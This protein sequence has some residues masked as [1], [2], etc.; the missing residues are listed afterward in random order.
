M[1]TSLL[2]QLWRER[3]G[4]SDDSLPDKLFLKGKPFTWAVEFP[5]ASF[6]GVPG[7]WLVIA[8]MGSSF[9]GLVVTLQFSV[10]AQITFSALMVIAT[11]LLRRYAGSLYT[12]MLVY[13]SLLCT[14][15]YFSWRFRHLPIDKIDW[16]FGWSLGFVAIE[17]CVF[18]YFFLGWLVRLWPIEIAQALRTTDVSELPAVDVL[19]L[20]S[21]DN[22]DRLVA[23]LK[24]CREIVWP[25]KKLNLMVIGTSDDTALV[26]T[27]YRFKAT[28]QRQV[29]HASGNTEGKIAAVHLGMSVTTSEVVLVI[30]A[31]DNNLF[32]IDKALL[33][34]TFGWFEADAGLG[35][36]YSLDHFLAPPSLTFRPDETSLDHCALVRRSAW[37][38]EFTDRNSQ[39]LLSL[40]RRSALLVKRQADTEQVLIRVD[41]ADSGLI[42]NLKNRLVQLRAVMRFY[43]PLAQ[44]VFFLTPIMHF[45]W[46]VRLVESN[47]EANLESLLVLAIP[48]FFLIVSLQ[49]RAWNSNRLSSVRELRE[50]ALSVYFY[51]ATAWSFLSAASSNLGLFLKRIVEKSKNFSMAAEVLIAGLGFANLVALGFGLMSLFAV[52]EINELQKWR[53]IYCFWAFINVAMLISYVAV[54]YESWQVRRFSKQQQFLQ[55]MLRLPF[56]RTVVCQTL[57]FPST[58]LHIVT[59][60]ELAVRPDSELVLSIFHN[61]Q[62]YALTVQVK[63]IVGLTT[64]LAIQPHHKS[65]FEVLRQAV[66]T[67]SIDWPNWLPNKNADAPLPLW[68]TNAVSSIPVKLIEYSTQLA[69]VLK[70]DFVVQ[71]WRKV[72][73]S[74]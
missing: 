57:N 6:W 16:T 4:K 31:R 35:L 51:F 61:N 50:L 74:K 32:S 27:T 12:M 36:L 8:L 59:P 43:F 7:L 63:T 52:F 53:L 47:S 40:W 58:D 54:Q 28:Y 39:T 17:L 11:A 42:Q 46:K 30:D 67:R 33:N 34:R 9:V 25:N 26:E 38:S 37:Q 2:L 49:A 55:G 60:V 14:T 22:N 29:S 64:H 21:G 48:H 44:L 68:L 10:N 5:Q 71:F 69:M 1:T 19:I 70:W 72:S 24:S 41:R 18:F 15:Q 62:P 73:Q 3:W 13:L 65:Q 45:L 20:V 23:C 56:G 66:F